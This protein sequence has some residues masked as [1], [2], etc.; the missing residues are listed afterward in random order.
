VGAV[1]VCQTV[2]IELHFLKAPKRVVYSG[3]YPVRAGMENKNRSSAL[4]KIMKT[5]KIAKDFHA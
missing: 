2:E 4:G 3:L 5:V 1:S